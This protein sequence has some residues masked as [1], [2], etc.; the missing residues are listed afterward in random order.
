MGAA[1]HTHGPLGQF[2]CNWVPAPTPWRLGGSLVIVDANDQPVARLS[3]TRGK[4]EP[5]E[6]NALRIVQCVNA[7][8][9]LMKALRQGEQAVSV[10]EARND[11]PPHIATELRSLATTIRAAIAKATGSAA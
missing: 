2:S 7:H 11:T 9:D 3:S 6:V 10:L 4:Y 1:Q 8:G 5:E